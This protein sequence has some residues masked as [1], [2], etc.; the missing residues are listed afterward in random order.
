MEHPPS[1]KSLDTDPKPSEASGLQRMAQGTGT[2]HCL[3]AGKV[4]VP[5]L[6]LKHRGGALLPTARHRAMALPSQKPFCRRRP[7]VP[8]RIHYF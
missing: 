6:V 5:R 2:Q 8:C 7:T 3:A 1:H 4:P